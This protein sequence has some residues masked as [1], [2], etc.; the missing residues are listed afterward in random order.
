MCGIAGYIGPKVIGQDT[1]N[2]TLE[3]MKN[4][5]PDHQKAVR[6]SEGSRQIHLLHA[7]LSIIDL[8]SRA[9]QPFE[10]RG[11][12]LVFNGEIYNYREVRREL[13]G[14][15]VVFHTSSD[16]EVLLEAYLRWGQDCVHRFEGMWAFAIYDTRSKTLFLSR[17]RF[18]EKPLY[19]FEGDGG[20][21]FGS[22]VKFLA[23]LSAHRF[24][25]NEQQL[26]RYLVNGYR[27]LYKAK[28]TYFKEIKELSFASSMEIID[29]KIRRQ[30]RYW[31]PVVREKQMSM[32]EAVEG[33][34][35]HL[36]ESMRIRLRSDVPISFCLSGGVDSASLVSI[37][38]KKFK[39]DIHTFS[40][41]D[42]DER[43]DERKNIQATIDDV[44]CKHTLIHISTEN[45]LERLKKLVK[46][47]DAPVATITYLVHSFLTQ[48]ASKNGYKVIFAGHAGDEMLTGYYD[49][50]ILHLY[51]M[52]NRPG[53]AECRAGWEKHILPNVRNPYLRDP[54]LYV[55][56]PLFRGHIY[57]D[58]Q[59]FSGFLK[60][61]FHED[62]Y[63]TQYSDSLLHNRMLNELFHEGVRLILH[64]DDLNSMMYSMENRC[65]FLDSNL[66]SFAHSIPVEHLIKD[67]YAKWVLR[68]S[69]KG[70]LNDQVR[71]D[72]QKKGFN[73]GVQSLFDFTDPEL[74]EYLLDPKAAIFN[75]VDRT[76]IDGL[77][78]AGKF[79]DSYNKFVFNFINARIFLELYE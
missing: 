9:N 39:A 61:P 31:D 33:F 78:Q 29:G 7:R 2:K 50:F 53:Y 72:R 77:L 45:S 64:E 69:V 74:R 76:K 51:E 30:W 17:D 12:W 42:D 35:H 55:K 6:L 37:A 19:I 23:T 15:G 54:D 59:Q 5:G 4:R 49:D 34:R 46:Y 75:I 58:A 52:K 71:L 79:T 62:F 65:P 43:Y 25:V 73:A 68:E 38:V 41:I 32:D 1:I 60:T 24:S 18:A 8:D 10:R 66:F 28:D 3:V 48:E 13:E 16:T 57:L 70:I 14:L 44:G 27:S 63:E 20:I 56:D 47:H 36:L 21:Y 40:I 26:F 22:E 67:G 11:V